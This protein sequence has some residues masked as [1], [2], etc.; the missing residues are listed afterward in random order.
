MA[1]RKANDSTLKK[2]IFESR[3]GILSLLFISFALKAGL[4]LWLIRHVNFWETGYGLYYKIAHNFLTTGG[5]YLQGGHSLYIADKL[6]AVRTPLYPLFIALIAKLSNF[7]A[8]AF[9]IAEAFISTLTVALVYKITKDFFS[10]N[11]AF[12]SAFLYAFYPYAFIH[13]TQLQENVLYNFFSLASVMCLLFAINK[14]RGLLFFLSGLVLGAATLTRA[15]HLMHTFSLIVLVLFILR[16]NLKEVSRYAGL[17]LI[18]L[19]RVL[20]PWLIRNKRLLGSFTITSL[21]GGTLA[22][23]HNE[24]TFRYFPYKGS[25]DQST[26]LYRSYLHETRDAELKAIA[27]NETLQNKWFRNLAVDYIVKHKKQTLMR[28]VYKVAVN[29]LGI[30]SPL[31]SPAKN[32]SYFLSYW[33]LT[34]LA[35]KSLPRIKHTVYFKLFLTLCLSQAAFSFI[36]WAHSSHRGFLD[37]MLAVSAGIGLALFL[38]SSEKHACTIRTF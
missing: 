10:T 27:G 15:S 25:I 5:L 20:S 3:I 17:I 34:L 24:F 26:R 29:F 22:E 32:W 16:K 2:A 36:F 12:L 33:L 7:S 19:T 6:Y 23:A 37:P 28:G 30:L 13:D 8:S 38:F 31:Q 35:L 14:K 9:I 11:A 1:A 18:G 4:R 21:T